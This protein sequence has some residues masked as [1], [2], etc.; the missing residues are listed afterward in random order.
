MTCALV[1]PIRPGDGSDI[2]GIIKLGKIG[3][4]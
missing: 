3:E 4:F 2:G 1:G